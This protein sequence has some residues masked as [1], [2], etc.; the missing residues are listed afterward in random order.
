[1]RRSFC[2]GLQEGI[3]IIQDQSMFAEWAVLEKIRARLSF[4]DRVFE[5]VLSV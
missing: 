2:L 1:M 4:C 3:G 5:F